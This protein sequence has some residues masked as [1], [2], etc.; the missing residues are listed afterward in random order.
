MADVPLY[1]PESEV[2]R[3]ILG[4]ARAQDW[5]LLAV[6]LEREQGLPAIDPV[7][8][9]RYWPGVVKFFEQYNDVKPLTGRPQSGKDLPWPTRKR[10]ACNEGPTKTGQV[11][12]I[13]TRAPTSKS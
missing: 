11:V 6:L 13:G 10:R 1:L 7:F 5:P 12:S 4:K 8:G 3:R 2:A 9:M